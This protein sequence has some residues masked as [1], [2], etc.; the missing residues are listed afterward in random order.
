MSAPFGE[1]NKVLEMIEPSQFEKIKRYK[2]ESN[3]AIV[4]TAVSIVLSLNSF[5]F[6]ELFFLE[7]ERNV[8]QIKQT[9]RQRSRETDISD[10]GYRRT[11][12]FLSGVGWG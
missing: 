9:S 5:C 10:T 3:H 12:L 1:K 11:I 6:R 7:T 8:L 4:E 2:N